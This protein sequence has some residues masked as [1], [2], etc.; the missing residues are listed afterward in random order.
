MNQIR[1]FAHVTLIVLTT[2][3]SLTS[4]LGGIALLTGFNAPPLTQLEGS[5]FKTFLLPGLALAV[6]VGGS[7]F[8]ASIFLIRKNRFS[9]LFST[10][11]GIVIMFFEFIEVLVI[12]S[13]VGIARNLQIFYF[14]LGIMI[15]M[16]SVSCWFFD[17][18]TDK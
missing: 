18:L 2:F 16:L 12:G 15:A 8:I 6:I 17:L 3:L 5:V 4:I 11:T 14:G 13:P 10:V 1:K 7:A 9:C